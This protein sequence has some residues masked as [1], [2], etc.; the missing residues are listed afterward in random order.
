M[1]TRP[2]ASS[3]VFPVQ[4]PAIPEIQ[5]HPALVP[6]KLSGQER[7]NALF[8]YTLILQ[9]PDALADK[10]GL[11]S[12]FALED[13]IGREL[14]CQ[15]ELEGHGHS[16]RADGRGGD[17]SGDGTVPLSSGRAVLG[18]GKVKQAFRLLGVEHEPAYRASPSA[19]QVTLYSILKITAQARDP[20]K[21]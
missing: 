3:R 9:T 13:F 2:F 5:G 8:E 12:N 11:G 19:Q 16:G 17:G 6:V 15:I 10:G 21:G 1:A 18:S 4:S 7:I 14:T 20:L